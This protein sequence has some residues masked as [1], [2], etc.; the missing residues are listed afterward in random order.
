MLKW[1]TNSCWKSISISPQKSLWLVNVSCLLWS[2]VSVCLVFIG[3]FLPQ[4]NTALQAVVLKYVFVFTAGTFPISKQLWWRCVCVCVFLCCRRRF[5]RLRP[6]CCCSL[7]C[8]TRSIASASLRSTVTATGRPS[9]ASHAHVS[10]LSTDPR[11]GILGNVYSCQCV[12]DF[13]KSVKI[14]R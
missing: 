12:R 10:L 3:R 14:L 11:S 9:H 6:R 7:C 13:C 2:F 5:L 8:Q 1:R 4:S